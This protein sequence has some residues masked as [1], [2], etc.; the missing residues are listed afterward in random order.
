MVARL[1]PHEG[2]TVCETFAEV[3]NLFFEL[4]LA[5]LRAKN[6]TMTLFVLIPWAKQCQS[7]DLLAVPLRKC[8]VASKRIEYHLIN[9]WQGTSVR[10]RD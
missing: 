4:T 6:D 10:I 5:R 1:A 2:L 3:K 7:M 8:Y 9:W